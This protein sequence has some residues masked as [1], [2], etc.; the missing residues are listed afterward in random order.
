MPPDDR[1]ARR[2]PGGRLGVQQQQSTVVPTEPAVAKRNA[3]TER[4]AVAERDAFTERDA[5]PI[6]FSQ[7][8]AP[9]PAEPELGP[10]EPVGQWLAKWLAEWLAAIGPARTDG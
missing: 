1:R 2:E 9:R 5:I 6:G 7:L 4:N 8:Q 3:L 10:A